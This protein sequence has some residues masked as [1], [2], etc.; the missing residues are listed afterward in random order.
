MTVPKPEEYEKIVFANERD[1]GAPWSF[2]AQEV[3]FEEEDG[4]Q[5]SHSFP[6]VALMNVWERKTGEPIEVIIGREYHVDRLIAALQVLKARM[7]L[8][9]KSR[10]LN[11]AKHRVSCQEKNL[12]QVQIATS[13]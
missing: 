6:P 10:E 13:R 5:G 8:Q 7:H 2:V 9:E 11:G 4:G 1:H 12:Q 3:F